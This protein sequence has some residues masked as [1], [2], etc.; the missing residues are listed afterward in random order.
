MLLT[1]EIVRALE[2]ALATVTTKLTLAQSY[3]SACNKLACL[4][5]AT[6]EHYDASVV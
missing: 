1:F 6:V 4:S 2:A 5:P 3:K